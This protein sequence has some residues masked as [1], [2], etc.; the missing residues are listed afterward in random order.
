[1]ITWGTSTVFG[2]ANPSASWLQPMPKQKRLSK[3]GSWTQKLKKQLKVGQEPKQIKTTMWSFNGYLIFRQ[4]H[5]GS[6]QFSGLHHRCPRQRSGG[7]PWPTKGSRE[8][9]NQQ[10]ASNPTMFH[11]QWEFQDPK[12]EVLYHIRPY[13][14]IFCGDIPL[15]RPY[16]GLIY[17][18]YL[19]FRFLKFPLTLCSIHT[20]PRNINNPHY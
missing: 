13:F 6:S 12:M 14:I 9:S 11:Y 16:I 5:G 10:S 2:D 15:H 18:R 20:T 4:T 17:G 1:M 8:Y 3:N 7:S 19:H